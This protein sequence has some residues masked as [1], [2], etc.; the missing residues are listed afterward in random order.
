MLANLNEMTNY[1]QLKLK[2]TAFEL[3]LTS[4][5]N[6]AVCEPESCRTTLWVTVLLEQSQNMS[7]QN[8]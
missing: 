6:G 1:P 4:M 5:P 3:L 7:L 2:G 8:P